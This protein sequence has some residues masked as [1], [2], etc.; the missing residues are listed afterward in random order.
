MTGIL[1]LTAYL[2]LLGVAAILFLKLAGDMPNPIDPPGGCVFHPRCPI[3]VARCQT[4]APALR[5]IGPG[6]QAA[7]H[8]A[9]AA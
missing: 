3:A 8:L 4:E 9:E 7:C 2:P 1:S 6:H 5:Q